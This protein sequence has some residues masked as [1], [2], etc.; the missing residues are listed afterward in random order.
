VNEPRSCPNSSLSSSDSASAAQC[1]FTNG[2]DA[3]G[4]RSWIGRGDQL[5]ARPRLAGD[6]HTR[7]RRRDLGDGLEHVL[8]RRRAADDVVEAVFL[9]QAR[10]EEA[11]LG[12]EP[13]GR[14]LALD[15]DG[16]LADVHRLRQVVARARAHRPH[17]RLDLAE[18][19]HDDDRQVR[20]ALPDLSEQLN[21][22]HAGHLEIRH[23]QIGRELLH[24]AQRLEPV[25]RRLDGVA[26]VAQ[27]L[28]ERVARVDLVVDDEN[29]S[30]AFHES[31]GSF[32][33]GPNIRTSGRVDLIVRRRR[34]VH[35]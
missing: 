28:E 24:L 29:A 11:R 10:P 9:G 33:P 26:V 18:G 22:V 1:S 16:Q 25:R 34:R 27:K 31:G 12:A 19:G 23:H 32:A 8:H 17:R 2:P 15:H 7:A 30:L 21:P 6:E 35:G 14:H 13:T 5:L 20:V 4:L 3:R